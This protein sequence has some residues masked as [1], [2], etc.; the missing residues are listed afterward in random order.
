[1]VPASLVLKFCLKEELSKSRVTKTLGKMAREE[2]ACS[3][4]NALVLWEHGVHLMQLME[5]QE[6][7]ELRRL[8]GEC[9][10]RLIMYSLH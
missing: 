8:E 2:A 3:V 4:I 9:L 5:K 7:K 6:R 10:F 1:M